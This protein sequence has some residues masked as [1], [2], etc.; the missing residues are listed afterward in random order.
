MTFDW[1]K[2]EL[3]EG[4]RLYNAGEYFAAHE[5]WE[6][7]W[8][9]APEP[10]KAFLQGIIQVAAAFHHFHRG[11]LLGTQRTFEKALRRLDPLPSDFGGIAVAQLRDDMRNR[12]HALNSSHPPAQLAPARIEPLCL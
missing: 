10:E 11:N 4:L 5:A 7:V 1:T 3:A 8:M 9:T 6:A 2:G 12:L